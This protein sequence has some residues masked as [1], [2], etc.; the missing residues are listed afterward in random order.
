MEM[1]A[2]MVDFGL[3]A[4]QIE[5]TSGAV[6]IWAAAYRTKFLVELSSAVECPDNRSW[7]GIGEPVERPTNR[8][9]KDKS[10]NTI[11][12]EIAQRGRSYQRQEKERAGLHAIKAKAIGETVWAARQ[13]EWMALCYID[14]SRHTN[15]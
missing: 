6:G 1:P 2:Q 14:Q 3:A 8:Q 9:G 15:C 5:I 13:F 10:I 7:N 11:A 4:L 12:H